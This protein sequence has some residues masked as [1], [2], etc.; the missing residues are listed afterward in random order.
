MFINVKLINITHQSLDDS[1]TF[2]LDFIRWYATESTYEY[3]V[4]QEFRRD[5]WYSRGTLPNPL[6]FTVDRWYGEAGSSAIETHGIMADFAL[7]TVDSTQES[8]WALMDFWVYLRN[9]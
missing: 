3:F 2:Q 1:T 8:G 5:I 6:N 7:P 4:Y 9:E